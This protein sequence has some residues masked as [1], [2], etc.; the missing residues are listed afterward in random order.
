MQTHRRDKRYVSIST[1]F[2]NIMLNL[3]T[4]YIMKQCMNS[5][6]KNHLRSSN[7]ILTP[8]YKNFKIKQFG[9]HKLSNGKV[10]Q[11]RHFQMSRYIEI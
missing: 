8:H 10:D 2:Q 11:K 9:A 7:V 1:Q 5:G 4:G 3:E 6:I